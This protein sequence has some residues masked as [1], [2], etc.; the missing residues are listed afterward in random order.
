MQ[1]LRC[2]AGPRKIGFLG[3]APAD[4]SPHV[5]SSNRPKFLTHT[6]SIVMT[7]SLLTDMP[8]IPDRPILAVRIHAGFNAGVFLGGLL[9]LMGCTGGLAGAML[10]KLF[11]AL[12]LRPDAVELAPRAVNGI[13]GATLKMHLP[14]ETHGHPDGCAAHHHVHR[15]PADILAVYQA[16]RLSDG[17][18]ALAAR[19]WNEL[20][21][22]EARVHGTTADAVHFHE[23]GRLSNVLSIGLAAHLLTRLKP[24]Q[25]AASPIPMTDG[26]VECAHGIVPYPAPALFAMLEGT[27]VR[28]YSG[29]GEPI[30]PT[31]LAVLK[32]FGA[33]FGPWPQMTVSGTAT[34]FAPAVFNHTPNGTLFVMG[35]EA[36]AAQD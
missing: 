11:P 6:P 13:A 3:E 32:G 1:T 5:E 35:E 7:T 20:A 30:T 33:F 12:D 2:D 19:V 22:A 36:P 16:S 24:V 34:V 28:P 21:R 31:G 9:S 23:V 15:R 17:A 27:A 14:P 8:A 25:I 18:Q 26:A 4:G 10:A 29:D